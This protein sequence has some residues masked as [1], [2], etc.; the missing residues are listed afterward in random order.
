MIDYQSMHVPVLLEE[1]M[2]GLHIT[3][4]DTILD[5]T[6]G[7][8]GHAKSLCRLLSPQGRYIGLDRDPALPM[9]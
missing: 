3:P 9:S 4:T 7:F 6:L 5:G 8:C 1:V 2:Q